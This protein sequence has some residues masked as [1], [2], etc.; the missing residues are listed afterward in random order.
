MERLRGVAIEAHHFERDDGS[1]APLI[2]NPSF[3]D[4]A[5]TKLTRLEA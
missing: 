1:A 4:R 5:E 2:G 3:H